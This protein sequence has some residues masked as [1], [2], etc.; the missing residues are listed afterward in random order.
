MVMTEKKKGVSLKEDS[1]CVYRVKGS[2][3]ARQFD[4]ETKVREKT[5]RTY[6]I[7]KSEKQLECWGKELELRKTSDKEWQPF[8]NTAVKYL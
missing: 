4:G 6:S 5:Q 8:E 7:N 3:I 1:N 2:D